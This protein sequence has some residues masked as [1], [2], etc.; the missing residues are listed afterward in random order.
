MALTYHPASDKKGRDFR[1]LSVPYSCTNRAAVSPLIGVTLGLTQQGLAIICACLPTLRPLLP[2]GSAALTRFSH[3]YYS[4][5]SSRRGQRRSQQSYGPQSS[6]RDDLP[7]Y[8]RLGERDIDRVHLTKV[9]GGSISEEDMN[10]GRAYPLN[11]I[12][13]RRS[14]EVV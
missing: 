9:T 13:V 7:A 14:L 11:T 4:Y 1:A 3:W 2:R 5:V 10:A 6:G 12:T 8:N